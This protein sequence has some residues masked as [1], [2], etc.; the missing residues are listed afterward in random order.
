L[1]IHSG[2]IYIEDDNEYILIHSPQ[3]ETSV[4]PA[5]SFQTKAEAIQKILRYGT[6]IFND[7]QISLDKN[8]S[9]QEEYAMP[10]IQHPFYFKIVR[11]YIWI[12]P[13]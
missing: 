8:I 2:R 11:F 12:Q 13:G 1:H 6:Y 7:P 4:P 9:N 3:I 10:D 5:L